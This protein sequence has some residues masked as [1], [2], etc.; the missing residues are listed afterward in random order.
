MVLR[1]GRLSA[2]QGIDQQGAMFGFAAL[3]ASKLLPYPD[4]FVGS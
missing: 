3:P 2:K 4:V 1:I